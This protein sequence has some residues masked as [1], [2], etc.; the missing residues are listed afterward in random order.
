MER[1]LEMECGVPIKRV[2][3]DGRM[4]TGPRVYAAG[5]REIEEDL[6]LTEVGKMMH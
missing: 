4:S 3:G 5:R 1:E 2:A 6:V